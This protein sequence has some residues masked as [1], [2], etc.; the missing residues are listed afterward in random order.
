M[1]AEELPARARGLGFGLLGMA[2]AMG[3]GWAAILYGGILEPNDLSWRWLYAAG[4]P[5]LVLVAVLRRQ[6]PESRRFLAA[7]D[8]GSL[9]ER[10]HEILRPPYRRWLILV[11][12]TACLFQLAQQAATFTIDFLQTD[13]GL[14]A[15]TANFMLVFAGL[16]GIPIMVLAG[17][18]SDRFGRRAVGCA[19]GVASLVGAA[20]LFW[21][22][23]GV[24]VL[25]PCMSLSLIGQLGSWPVLQTYASE[26]FPTSLRGQATAWATVFRVIG[27][28]GSL[29]LA[30]VLLQFTNQSWTATFLGVGPLAAVIIVAL[31][32]PDTHGKELE[33]IVPAPVLVATAD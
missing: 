12:A 32:F 19:F 1:A 15:S 13:R 14:S 28:S 18:L 29:G 31:T 23:G 26:L 8:S 24:P 6:L 16:P 22:P 4:V 5:P 25:L 30:A 10:W 3:V 21:L 20:G 9:S 11:V 33:D 7:R 2:T 27:Q 17:S